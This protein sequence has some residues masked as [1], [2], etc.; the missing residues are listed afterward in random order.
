[1]ENAKLIWDQEKKAWICTGC[2]AIYFQPKN[3]IPKASYCMKCR[4]EWMC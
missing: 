2:G 3:W 1:M 4:K